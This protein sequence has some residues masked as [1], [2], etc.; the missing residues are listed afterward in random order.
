MQ[1]I[2]YAIAGIIIPK[3]AVLAAVGP[4]FEG[5]NTGIM[6]VPLVAVHKNNVGSIN[7]VWWWVNTVD[8]VKT[9][10]FNG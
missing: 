4:I 6:C 10:L 9:H 3:N 2:Y 7:G 5:G 1:V 8:V